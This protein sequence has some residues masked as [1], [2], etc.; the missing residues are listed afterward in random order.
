MGRIAPNHLDIL[1]P[2]SAY[3]GF[4]GVF[5]MAFWR[6][7]PLLDF[8]DY[9]YVAR[10]HGTKCPAPPSCLNP[11]RP[12]AWVGIPPPRPPPPR[13]PLPRPP[14]PHPPLPASASLSGE[15]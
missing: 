13:I 3:M 12:L 6:S 14:L 5:D 4:W 7:P 9:M 2:Q 10:R 11:S 8:S 1:P 15:G